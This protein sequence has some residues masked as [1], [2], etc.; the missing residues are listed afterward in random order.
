MSHTVPRTRLLA[1]AYCFWWASGA[2]A[3]CPGVANAPDFAFRFNEPSSFTRPPGSLV[4]IPVSGLLVTG[5]HSSGRGAQGWQAGWVADKGSVVNLFPGRA[6]ALE[7]FGWREP[8]G[9][10]ITSGASGPG[11]ESAGISIVS[12]SES[13]TAA[14]PAATSS[15]LFRFTLEGRA[16]PVGVTELWTVSYTDGVRVRGTSITNCVTWDDN[17]VA[18]SLG[19]YQVYVTGVPEDKAG[20]IQTWN[21]LGP[22]QQPFGPAPSEANMRLDYHTGGVLTETNYNPVPGMQINTDFGGA[23][24]SAGLIDVGVPDWNPGGIPTWREHVDADHT[25]Y[26]NEIWGDVDNVVVYAVTY[27]RF[28]EPQN[29]LA[30]GVASD[31]SIQVLL[32][33]FEVGIASVARGISG[34]AGVQDVFDLPPISAGVHKIMVKVFEG[35][36]G[37]AFRLRF[38]DSITGVPM[39]EGF[40]VSTVPEPSMSTSLGVFMLLVVCL[41]RRPRRAV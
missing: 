8:S 33:D 32:D 14:L 5:E 25:I 40:T 4:R 38:Q 9:F 6:A 35:G 24:A 16:P 17:A 26:F 11:G 3:Q 19:S 37:H 12:L 2:L 29:G 36:G 28:D 39:T 1:A 30:L 15:E 27:V 10:E 13:G 21:L 41:M 20:F 22:F 7:P 34:R 23:A 18:P 31:D